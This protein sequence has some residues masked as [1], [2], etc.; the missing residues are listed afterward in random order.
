MTK[1][2]TGRLYP[3]ELTAFVPAL[4]VLNL[5]L[6]FGRWHGSRHPVA[7]ELGL[8]DGLKVVQALAQLLQL[9]DAGVQARPHTSEAVG[10]CVVKLSPL[11]RFLERFVDA[12]SGCVP[13]RALVSR[14][15]KAARWWT[16][17][18]HPASARSPRAFQY[19]LLISL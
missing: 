1:P 17:H 11:E 7:A 12:A 19:R 4:C 3:P 8:V 10:E 5:D 15:A 16:C 2:F 14:Q 13:T 9:G 6:T 18:G